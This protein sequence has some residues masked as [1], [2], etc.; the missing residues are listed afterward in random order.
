MALHYFLIKIAT[1]DLNMGSRSAGSSILQ[2]GLQKS[3]LPFLQT[4]QSWQ[5][6]KNPFSA[7][8]GQPHPS[9]LLRTVTGQGLSPCGVA[10]TMG[11]GLQ[12]FKEMGR[13]CSS[14]LG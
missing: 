5:G 1:D 14:Q 10:S 8:Q 2:H 4:L 13:K 12:L 9:V 3:F 11:V 7:W 6:I